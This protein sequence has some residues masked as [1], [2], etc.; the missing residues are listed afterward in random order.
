MVRVVLV[1]ELVDGAAKALAAM[2]RH[3]VVD[4]LPLL[5]LLPAVMVLLQPMVPPIRATVKV[6]MVDM[7]EHRQHPLLMELHRPQPHM[8]E[9]LITV[10]VLVV[11]R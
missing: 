9:L 10:E 1:L 11:D 3:M 7:V 4:M 2:D 6:I 8:A 5:L